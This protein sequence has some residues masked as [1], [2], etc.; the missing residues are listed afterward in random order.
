M[1][2]KYNSTTKEWEEL[3]KGS[4]EGMFIDPILKRL[5]DKYRS[6]LKQDLD[7][8]V[9]IDGYEGAGKSCLA[10]T[11]G[12][13]FDPEG[14][15][16]DRIV[17][18][19]K[20]FQAVVP[21]VPPYSCIVL[22]EAY[23]GLNS[24]SVMGKES[25]AMNKMFTEIRDRNLFMI[26]VL[27]SYFELNKYFAIHRSLG[28]FHVIL[29]HNRKTDKYRRGGVH[30]YSFGRKKE[31]YIQ[32]K[33]FLDYCK[34][35]KRKF[36]FGKFWAVDLNEYKKKKHMAVD[37]AIEEDKDTSLETRNK[38]MRELRKTGKS[39]AEIAEIVGM[40]RASVTRALKSNG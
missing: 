14:F 31:M 26:I 19:P 6:L 18:N 24:K 29:H 38:L 13:Y 11:M 40:H 7:A 37:V 8:V 25:K 12:K 33:Q 27:P 17:F 1:K 15:C 3:P 5:L 23:G 32:G 22:D 34:K 39:A 9:V 20:Q 28:L 16:I 21:H 10:Q 35:P 2:I 36:Y 4:K 30:Y